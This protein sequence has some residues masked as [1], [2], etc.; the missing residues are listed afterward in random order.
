MKPVR[1]FLA[2]DH[3]LFRS[4][5][6]M[7]LDRLADIEVIGEADNGLDALVAL[8]ELVPRVALLDISMPGL[9]GIELTRRIKQSHPQIVVVILSMHDERAFVL[10][11][12]RAGA[13]G[14]LLKDAGRE[15][16]ARVI[17]EVL[18][19]RK[20][21]S[22]AIS[23]I[24]V[25]EV[26]HPATDSGAWKVLSAR[27]RQVLQLIAEGGS[28]REIAA[29]LNLSIKTIESHRKQIMD[30]LDLH[31]IAE[32]TRYAIREGLSPL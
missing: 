3:R 19:G 23:S 18:Q 1:I 24:L 2:D 11:S 13:D 22:A 10:E 29:G 32:L 14:Y 4:G 25:D 30:K 12:L 17:H 26:L 6:R 28:T 15:D 5:L 7:M 27:E 8:K 20:A 9:N 31:S 16:L 21:V